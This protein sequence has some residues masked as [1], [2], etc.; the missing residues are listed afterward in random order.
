M[1]DNIDAW[2]VSCACSLTALNAQAEKCRAIN[3]L[4]PA[5]GN[6]PPAFEVL[7]FV[8]DGNKIM[9]STHNRLRNPLKEKL[10]RGEPVYSMTVRLVRTVDIASIAYTAGFDSIY[11]DMEHSS[12]PLDAAGHICMACIGLGVTPFVRVPSLDAHF[13]ARVLDAGAL[14][15]VA[16]SVQSAA[17]AR[18]VVRAAK[19]PPLGMRSV[20]GAAP[21]MNYRPL[22]S[23][24]TTRQLDDATMIIAMI[25]SPE[26]LAAV[27]E[28]AAVEGVD[29]LLVGAS[30]L[31]TS[32]GF[33]GQV[34]HPLVLDAY[35]RTL[36]A[37][38]AHNKVLGV[39]GLGGKPEFMKKLLSLGA[40][41]V[42]T[43][44]DVSFLVAAATQK[45]MQ[46]E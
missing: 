13:I 17:D 19:H 21:Q 4:P 26:G 20:A 45:R 12:F 5:A 40:Q 32:L 2:W 18:A 28:I 15:I 8:A 3:A 25:E 43:G 46:F 9:N 11:I 6:P 14:G 10:A 22:P 30:D 16:P 36:E 41:Y 7:T 35:L 27:D 33:P 1:R 31:S 24:E 38:R 37:C 34:D 44:N 42:S 29:I 39:G 23:E